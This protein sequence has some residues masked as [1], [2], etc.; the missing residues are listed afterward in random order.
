MRALLLESER[1]LAAIVL[2]VKG[3]EISGTFADWLLRANLP[4]Q[5]RKQG[6]KTIYY[7]PV[8][9]RQ[10]A[11]TIIDYLNEHKIVEEYQIRMNELKL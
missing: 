11:Q 1:N 6:K 4:I 5:I 10:T 9:D 3:T 7:L 8:K 2:T